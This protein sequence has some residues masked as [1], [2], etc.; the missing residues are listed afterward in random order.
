[1][2][3]IKTYIF[4]LL[5]LALVLV[6]DS[7]AVWAGVVQLAPNA[8]QGATQVLGTGAARIYQGTV[9]GADNRLLS[10][11]SYDASGID[12]TRGASIELAGN[13]SGD[14]GDIYLWAGNGTGGG[15]IHVGLGTSGASFI[16]SDQNDATKFTVDTSGNTTTS[17]TIA[18]SRTTDIGW[19]LVSV[20][21]QACNTTCTSACIMGQ[22]TTSK[23]FLSCSDATADICLCAGAS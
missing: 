6:W 7:K 4:A 13:E 5:A 16:I 14:V 9:D 21:N 23:A 10:F 20:A 22:E 18:S 8:I 11:L 3:N 19:T 15:K 12:H 17:G 2:R 1:M